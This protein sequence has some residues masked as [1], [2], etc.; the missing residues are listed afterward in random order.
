LAHFESI[1][2]Y[3]SA[4]P[5]DCPYS[6]LAELEV[7]DGWFGDDPEMV[8]AARRRQRDQDRLAAAVLADVEADA[9]LR[10]EVVGTLAPTTATSFYPLDGTWLPA[11][12]A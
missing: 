4:H 9:L 6:V 1:P 7:D 2:R 10:E 3:D 11:L 5:P 8:D 12:T